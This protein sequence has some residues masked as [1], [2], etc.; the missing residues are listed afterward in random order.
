MAKKLEDE[1]VQQYFKNYGCEALDKYKNRRTSMKFRC[2]CGNISEKT[3][4][5][6]VY[7]YSGCSEC[8]P[9]GK[10]TIEY[11]RKYF[12][13][14]G[15]KL[16]ETEYIGANTKMRYICKCGREAKITFG[17]FYSGRRCWNCRNDKLT[18]ESNPWYN[19]N[20]TDREREVGRNY[21]GYKAWRKSVY[22]RD[23]Y[24]CQKCHITGCY[25]N[26]HHIEAYSINKELR[27]NVNN[28]IT[29]CRD[30][31]NDF[32]HQYGDNCTIIQLQEFL[33]S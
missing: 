28:G 27:T 20:L 33:R 9:T 6:F 17:H 15:C 13:D 24:T 7:G 21:S 2:K 25:L 29:F 10:H 31:H 16:L 11:V 32:H 22:E 5:C 19:P 18:G 23:N 30:C 12:E 3:F 26:A 4:G 8:S 14:R 1:Y